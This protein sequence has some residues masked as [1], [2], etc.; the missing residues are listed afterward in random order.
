MDPG[1]QDAEA[2]EPAAADLELP[3]R[4]PTGWIVVQNVKLFLGEPLTPGLFVKTYALFILL[5]FMLNP[6]HKSLSFFF[7]D[8]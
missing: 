6:P 2:P 5:P 7:H 3:Q 8:L 1:W 4:S